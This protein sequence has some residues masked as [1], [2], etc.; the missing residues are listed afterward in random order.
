MRVLDS[1]GIIR[2]DLD[3]S[4][5][6][7]LITNSVLNELRDET[8]ILA[9]NAAIRN[10]RIQIQDPSP[11]YIQ[12]VKIAAEKTGDIERL[13]ETDIEALAVA[14]ET[15][16]ILV[17][18]DYS[19]QNIAEIL[20]VKYERTSHRGITRKLTWFKLCPGCKRKYPYSSTCCDVCGCELVKRSSII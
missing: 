6:K 18:D 16:H 14:L 8:T 1:S 20:S 11:G 12:K 19:M 17:T 13:S 15:G 10:K 3:F 2:S 5:G 9:V 4:K 7:H